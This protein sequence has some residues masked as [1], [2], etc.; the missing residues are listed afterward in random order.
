MRLYDVIKTIEEVAL[1]QPAVN[2]IVEQDV[3]GLNDTPNIKYGVFAWLQN[4]HNG[5]IAEGSFR[6]SFT[7]F[8]VDRLLDDKSNM[9]EVQSVGV[10]VLTNILRT[11]FDG[12]WDISEY[13]VK[14]FNERFT[15]DCS[16]AFA[17]VT[18]SVP[19]ESICAET[20]NN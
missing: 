17:D 2:T 13:S 4:N 11:L 9:L 7:L 12:G 18:I 20:Y 14:T 5:N 6:Y 16:G 15:D 1:S 3:Y 10:S 8:Y 19:L